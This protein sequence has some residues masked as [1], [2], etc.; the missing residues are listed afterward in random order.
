[1]DENIIPVQHVA[2]GNSNAAVVP[3]VVLSIHT[4]RFEVVD[5]IETKSLSASSSNLAEMLDN[6]KD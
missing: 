5:M 6:E 1:M 2:E 4:S 3:S